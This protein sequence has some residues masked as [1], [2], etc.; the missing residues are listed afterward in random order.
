MQHNLV[1]ELAEIRDEQVAVI[2][3]IISKV[4][5]EKES[6]LFLNI[7]QVFQ[8]G[9]VIEKVILFQILV[10]H[11]SINATILLVRMK[12]KLKLAFLYFVDYGHIY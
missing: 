1:T 10:Q 8:G 4:L 6:T 11:V 5:P 7:L 9:T 3:K 12:P 2:D